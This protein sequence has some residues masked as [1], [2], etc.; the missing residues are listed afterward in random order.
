MG[1]HLHGPRAIALA[2]SIAVIGIAVPA[3][4]VAATP[5]GSPTLEPA[6]FSRVVVAPAPAG[7]V[8]ASR[9]PSTE[10]RDDAAPA[11]SSE[12]VMALATIRTR[13]AKLH[14]DAATTVVRHVPRSKAR[15][16][17]GGSR[18]TFASG[19]SAARN[20]VVQI[21]LAQ[22]NDRYVAGGTGPDTFDC[23]GLVRYAYNQAG[24]GGALGGGHSASAMLAWGRSMGLT[25]RTNGRVGDVVIY[26]DGSHAGIYIGGGRIVS[27]LNPSQGIR[28]TGLYALGAPFTAFIHTRI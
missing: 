10:L 2:T 1:F 20:R 6:A 12:T 11:A 23:S 19:S 8:F 27:A 25:S 4:L 18:V 15:A 24:V 21:A 7:P 17:V 5:A 26:G 28:V 16:S 22:L 3:A 13:T 9:V 14:A